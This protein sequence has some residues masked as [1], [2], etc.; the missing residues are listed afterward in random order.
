MRKT[1][2]ITCTVIAIG[3]LLAV[4]FW[5]AQ[6]NAQDN[7]PVSQAKEQ[8]EIEQ[9]S[10]LI[11]ENQPQQGLAIIHRY[12]AELS[13]NSDQGKQWRDLFIR[14]S[15]QLRN[16]GPL[17]A[18][19]HTYPKAFENHEKATIMVG[20]TLLQQNKPEEFDK[21][22]SSWKGKEKDK[23]QWTM[24]DADNLLSQDKRNEAI[25]LLNSTTF[26]GKDEETRLIKLA[27][28]TVYDDPRKA[29]EYLD[30]AYQKDPTD[31]SILSYRAKLLEAAGK[32]GLALA[33]YIDAVQ[34]DPES[35]LYRDQLAEFYLR[36]GDYQSALQVWSDSLAAPSQDYIWMKALF[37]NRMITPLHFNWKSQ[38]VPEGIL[39]PYVNYLLGLKPGQYWDQAAFEKMA[40]APLYQNNI[41]STFWLKLLN[42]LKEGRESTASEILRYTPFSDTSFDPQIEN[43]LKYTLALRREKGVA[44]EE[45]PAEKSTKAAPAVLSNAPEEFQHQISDARGEQ[46][47]APHSH[48]LFEQ[49]DQKKVSP[50]LQ[51]VLLSPEA[52]TAIFLA[53]GWME[54][55]LQLHKVAV[56]P[57]NF[58]DWLAESLTKALA[59]NRSK[60]EALA[61]AKE[62]KQTAALEL[63]TAELL[64]GTGKKKA[65]LTQLQKAASADNAEIANRA[66]WLLSMNALERGEL[67]KAQKIIQSR[68]QLADDVLGKETLAK[69]ALK[70]GNNEEAEKIYFSIM[71]KSTEAKSYFARI[72]FQQ[73]D[74]PKAKA[75]TE[76]LMRQH[77]ADTTLRENYRQILEHLP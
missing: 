10:K 25:N 67:D 64:I 32:N 49:I 6:E 30:Q 46:P 24:L 14:A 73:K 55:G 56:M 5:P 22:R 61:F 20:T 29:W 13:K 74:Y 19:Y 42:A 66:T 34:A 44:A 52:F 38:K 23:A 59:T 1:S 36:Q 3:T 48:S 69:I 16:I 58:P 27:L 47:A 53:A 41:Q 45:P 18:L 26:Q 54:D 57:D 33:E 71:D 17:M 70:R 8:G 50:E 40:Y 76:E 63:L 43:A 35:S 4:F 62:Q 21:L 75:L 39:K 28:M 77:P 68:P 9:A 11:E 15:E 31:P 65:G 72:A 7:S 37:W 12:D 60:E 2:I 51:T